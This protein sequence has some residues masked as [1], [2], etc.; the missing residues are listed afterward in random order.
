FGYENVRHRPS[1]VVAYGVGGCA[2]GVTVGGLV[3]GPAGGTFG[4]TGTPTRLGGPSLPGAEQP[5]AVP[6]GQLA[7]VISNWY[8]DGS[9][10]SR[11]F[12]ATLRSR[13]C[14]TARTCTQFGSAPS[15]IVTLS[16]G[17]IVPLAN[18][19]PTRA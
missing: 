13:R 4:S 15:P 6:G 19:K 14:S 5:Q 9:G 3:A 18:W 11:S 10:R 7:P 17:R 1:G 2:G 16:Y 12:R 8:T